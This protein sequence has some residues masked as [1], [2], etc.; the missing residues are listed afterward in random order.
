MSF[1]YSLNQNE[2][3]GKDFQIGNHMKWCYCLLWLQNISGHLVKMERVTGAIQATASTCFELCVCNCLCMKMM[4]SILLDRQ[5]IE[6]QGQC[7]LVNASTVVS[8]SFWPCLC[9]ADI[10][11]SAKS[12][13]ASPLSP[14]QREPTIHIDQVECCWICEIEFKATNITASCIYHHLQYHHLSTAQ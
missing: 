9:L 5:S 10:A 3:R 6:P 7:M 11:W 12:A 1:G 2:T 14:W 13:N 8:D 4:D